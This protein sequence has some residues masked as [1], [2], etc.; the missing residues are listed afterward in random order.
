MGIDSERLESFRC[1]EEYSRRYRE[2][3]DEAGKS[4]SKYIRDALE[5][6]EPFSKLDEDTILEIKSFAVR[7][8]SDKTRRNP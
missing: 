2:K 7:F 5:F 6:Y 4:N 3:A 1:S 8:L